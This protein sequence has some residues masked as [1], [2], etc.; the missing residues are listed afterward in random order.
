M[1]APKSHIAYQVVTSLLA[2][3][4]VVYVWVFV[5]SYLDLRASLSSS[6]TIEIWGSEWPVSTIHAM[7][8][9][10]WTTMFVLLVS[11]SSQLLRLG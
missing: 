7:V 11:D 10:G 4:S 9:D 8:L 2:I 1:A 6:E 3:A 5:D